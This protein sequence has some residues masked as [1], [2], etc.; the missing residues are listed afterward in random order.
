MTFYLRVFVWHVNST[1]KFFGVGDSQPLKQMCTFGTGAVVESF[2][3]LGFGTRA[4]GTGF[5]ALGNG[6][7]A[8]GTGFG[9]QA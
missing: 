7:R 6:T 3:A 9:A 1:V 8:V 2:G 5:G 4:V